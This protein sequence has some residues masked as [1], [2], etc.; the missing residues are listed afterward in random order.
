MVGVDK[1][2]DDKIA[3]LLVEEGLLENLVKVLK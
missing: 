1:F 2:R 3:H